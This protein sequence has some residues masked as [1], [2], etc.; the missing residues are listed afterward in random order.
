MP[1]KISALMILAVL[2][3]IVL[4]MIRRE[5]LTFKYAFGWLVSIIAGMVVV[6]ADQAAAWVAHA[7]GFALLSNFIFFCCLGAAVFMGLLL[8]VFLCQQ[9][10]RNECM[11]KRIA[12][13]EK[14]LHRRGRGNEGQ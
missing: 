5:K 10:Q 3:V 12:L 4:D 1:V 2:F 11:A 14:E 6:W 8:T 9:S 13:L 7:L